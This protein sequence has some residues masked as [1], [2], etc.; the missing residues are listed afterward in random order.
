MDDAEFQALPY[1]RNA[2]LML[3]NQRGRVFA[4]KRLDTP[5]AWQMPQGGIDKGEAPEAAA[6]RELFEETGIAPEIVKILAITPDWIKYDFPPEVAQKLWTTKS[7]RPKYRGQQQMWF[8]LRFLGDDS[9]IRIDTPEPEF[10]E[11]RWMEPSQIID[12]IVP[13]K[14]DIYRQVFSSFAPW[15]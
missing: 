10:S 4:G 2:G 12:H 9:Q 8:L 11:W 14:R 7:G 15:L 13:F 6:L 5:D 1:R 3:L